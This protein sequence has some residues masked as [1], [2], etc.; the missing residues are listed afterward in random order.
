MIRYE[1]PATGESCKLIEKYR[2]QYEVEKEIG[3][4]RYLIDDIE[5]Q[6]QSQ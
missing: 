5:G 3:K 4:D 1:V 6:K 2:G